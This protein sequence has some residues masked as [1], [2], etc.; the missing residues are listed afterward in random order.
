LRVWPECLSCLL[1]STVNLARQVTQ[2][3][4]L[5]R[6]L[7]EQNLLLKPFRGSVFD[8]FAANS[9]M[10]MWRLVVEM[11]GDPNPLAD[12][13]REQNTAAMEF[14]PEARRAVAESADPLAAALKLCIAGNVLDTMVG[15]LHPP[16]RQ[17]IAEVEAQTVDES[18]LAE[19]QRRVRSARSIL[20]FTDNCGEIVFDR[21]FLETLKQEQDV[22]VVLVAREL[23][24]INDATVEDA[25]SV[26]LD[27]VARVISSGIPIPLPSTDLAL[28]SEEVRRLVDE[29]DM[30]ISKG[31]ANFELLD[32]QQ[33]LQGKVTFLMHG[34]CQPLCAVHG[35]SRGGL[36]ISNR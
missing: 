3:E 24:S 17:M 13:K 28:V 20:Y 27:S 25:L 7:V 21:L 30:V 11:T 36:I 22:D 4:K 9:T 18:A 2:D 14:L 8:T 1:A 32:E 29:A 31:G 10:E 19:F 23:P 33:V 26:G 5:V 16:A 34:K 15:P 12:K 35:V 6:D